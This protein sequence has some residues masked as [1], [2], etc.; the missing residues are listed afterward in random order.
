MNNVTIGDKL[1]VL[2]EEYKIVGIFETGNLFTDENIYVPLDTLQN[3][4][5]T[6]KVSQILVKTTKGAND[7]L[8]SENI[9]AMIT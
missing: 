5:D 1:T 2:N 9:K 7:T 4:T 8:I 3:R 6:N